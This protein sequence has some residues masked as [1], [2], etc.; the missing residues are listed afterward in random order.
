MVFAHINP[1]YLLYKVAGFVVSRDITE[2]VLVQCVIKNA[3][4]PQIARS[5]LEL[6]IV[7]QEYHVS[8][9]NGGP[10]F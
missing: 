1:V 5:I 3:L 10:W 2:T 9:V 6:F 7:V 4:K 8:L